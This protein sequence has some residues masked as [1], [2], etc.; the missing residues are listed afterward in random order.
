MGGMRRENSFSVSDSLAIKGIAIILLLFHHLYRAP[1]LYAEFSVDFLFLEGDFITEL[2]SYFKVCVGVFAFISGFG[3]AKAYKKSR[4]IGSVGS[5]IGKRYVKSMAPF[6]IVYI[7]AV[8][9]TECLNGRVTKTYFTDKENPLLGAV[10]MI[11]DFLG[12]R[13]YTQTPQLD[14][15]WWYLGMIVMIILLVPLFVKIIE[16]YGS[17]ILLSFAVIVPRLLGIKFPGGTTP[18]SF[19]IPVVLGVIFEHCDGFKRINDFKIKF[20][21]IKA[22]EHIITFLL[23]LGL[24]VLSFL[25]Y[26]RVPQ[27]VSWELSYGVVPLVL[28]MFL[29]KYVVWIPYLK[30]VLAFLGKHSANMFFMHT[31]IRAYLRNFIYETPNFL[32]SFLIF[33]LI[34]LIASIVLEIFKKLIR[35]DFLVDKVTSRL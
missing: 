4:G 28:I 1:A 26:D 9:A 35:F 7:I 19:L 11:L 31:L 25:Y 16:K 3:I 33:F 10:Y 20:F 5:F 23:F 17:F 24:L 14:S 12:L 8:I 22:V 32:V 2:F 27:K 34:T 15:S 13:S 18:L 6:W 30:D 21:G 29:N